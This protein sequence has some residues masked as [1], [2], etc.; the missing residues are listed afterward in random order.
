MNI[1]AGDRELDRD[2]FAVDPEEKDV[3]GNFNSWT[4]DIAIKS[5]MEGMGKYEEEWERINGNYKAMNLAGIAD[6]IIQTAINKSK[7]NK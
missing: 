7:S 5:T 6:Y 2:R 3:L 1:Q 4:A